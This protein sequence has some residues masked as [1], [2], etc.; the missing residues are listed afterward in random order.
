MN[1]VAGSFD[2]SHSGI[3]KLISVDFVRVL[4]REAPI[5][6]VCQSRVPVA[7]RGCLLVTADVVKVGDDGVE[8]NRPLDSLVV[9]SLRVDQ[10]VRDEVSNPHV[11]KLAL[12]DVDSFFTSLS[13]NI[14]ALNQLNTGQSLLLVI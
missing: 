2:L 1:V 8:I 3:R 12:D 10:I 6:E 11:A 9:I 5:K 13:D 4:N 14:E 7:R